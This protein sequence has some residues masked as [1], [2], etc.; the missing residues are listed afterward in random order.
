MCAI[1]SLVVDDHGNGR[2][3]CGHDDYDDDDDVIVMVVIRKTEPVA[4]LTIDSNGIC[5]LNNENCERSLL[6][7]LLLE[8]KSRKKLFYFYR[9]F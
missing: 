5:R 6:H 7:F 9:M 8:V 2:Y 4:Y 1:N 3:H